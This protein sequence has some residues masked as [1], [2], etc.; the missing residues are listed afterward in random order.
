MLQ[1]TTETTIAVF[2][3]SLPSCVASSLPVSCSSGLL[4]PELH[5]H[6]V[7]SPPSGVLVFCFRAGGQVGCVSPSLR[8]SSG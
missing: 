7:S 4:L 5:P 8:L 1:A 2:G 6:L 3:S